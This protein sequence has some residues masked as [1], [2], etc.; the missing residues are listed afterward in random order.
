V[1]FPSLQVANKFELTLVVS[2]IKRVKESQN[3]NFFIL[4][5]I[6]VQFFH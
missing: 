6:C 1:K 2:E 4:S 5:Q 3:D